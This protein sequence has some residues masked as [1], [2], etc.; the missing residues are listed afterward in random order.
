M[1]LPAA[2]LSLHVLAAVLWVGGL[3]FA[4]TALRPATG[5]LQPPDRCRLWLGVF[6][7]FFPMAW[8]AVLV[9]LVTG[10]WMV[11]AVFGGMRGAGMYIH[12]MIG[13]GTL[14]MLLFAHVWFG[15]Y[16]KLGDA[17]S[18]ENWPEAGK[19]IG[20]IRPVVLVNIILGAIVI[21]AATGGRYMI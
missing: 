10:F 14:M 21:I 8:G 7:R 18:A 3:F 4:Y 1:N 15:P 20:R 9:L 17:V 11:E 6:Q 16:R 13:I 12:L 2:L 19:Q 5:P